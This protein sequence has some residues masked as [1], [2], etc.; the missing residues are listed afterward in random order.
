VAPPCLLLLLSQA[1]DGILVLLSQPCAHQHARLP[2]SETWGIPDNFLLFCQAPC[3]CPM[4]IVAGSPPL[5]Y[6]VI[7]VAL[8][9]SLHILQGM[10]AADTKQQQVFEA[11]SLSAGPKA[12]LG[13][14]CESLPC[15]I[16]DA[17]QRLA[18]GA[19]WLASEH[20][21]VRPVQGAPRRMPAL[22]IQ[23]KSF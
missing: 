17:C 14:D 22:L 12:T 8:H 5:C 10:A 20:Q 21:P 2:T 16:S 11:P 6:A 23:L 3:Q 7:F 18:E 4:F 13:N 19:F 15:R 1:A 9:E